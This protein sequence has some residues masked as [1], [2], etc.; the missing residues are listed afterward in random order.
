MKLLYITNGINGAGGLERVLS[1]KASYLAEHYAYDVTILCL[2]NNDKDPFYSFSDRIKMLSITVGGNPIK[3]INQYKNG[4][5]RIV[6]E[7]NPDVISVCDDGL[8]GFFIPKIIGKN[9][10]VIYERHVSKEIEMN[11]SFSS[12][13]KKLVQTKWKVMEQL[14]SSFSKFVVLTKG[15][16]LEWQSLT[17]MLVIPNP[18]S[19]YPEKSSMLQNKKVIA[20]GKQGF[21]KGYDRLL[22]AWQIVNR[23]HPDW[24]LEIYGTIAPEYKLEELSKSLRISDSVC[25]YPPEK[26]IQS[27][28]LEA[29]IYVMSSRFEGFGMVLIEAMACGVPCVSFDC[30]YGPADIIQ[31]EVDGYVVA[32]GNNDL[33]ALRINDLIANKD[34]RIKMGQKAKINVQ[35][36]SS[37]I[38]VKQWDMLFKQLVK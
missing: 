16:T 23:S 37:E 31:N 26:D 27:K 33:F 11:E 2:N 20:V 21:Q 14:A 36:F 25:F 5:E 28:Y 12:L 17:N 10:P 1:I 30:N 6:R 9:I 7:L 19:F 22:A 4:I 8:K 38:I 35:R 13:K 18:L 24:Q 3:Y 32:N 15:N 29:S 34:Q